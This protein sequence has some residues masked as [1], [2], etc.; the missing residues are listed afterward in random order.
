MDALEF[1]KTKE[2]MCDK[3]NS[4]T[5]IGCAKCPIGY[6]DCNAYVRLFPEKAIKAVEG[7]VSH[8]PIA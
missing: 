8:N 3:Y 1:I 5:G 6:R 2:R 4:I 7:W